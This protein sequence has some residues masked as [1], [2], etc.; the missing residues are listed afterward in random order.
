MAANRT[1]EIVELLRTKITSR[2]LLAGDVLAREELL[3]QDFGVSRACVRESLGILKAQG[4]LV[5]RRGKYGGT[6]ISTLIDSD[7]VD[8]LYRDLVLMD[9]MKIREILEARLLIE[10]EAARR[11]ASGPLKRP[12]SPHNEKSWLESY[13]TFHNELGTHANNPFYQISIR[14]FMKFITTF[15]NTL[16]QGESEPSCTLYDHDIQQ[17]VINAINEQE[18]S[19]AFEKMYLYT[20][21]S[22]EK[23]LKLE[24]QFISAREALF[25]DSPRS[26][27]LK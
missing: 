12:F 9:Q 2:Q 16:C 10:P 8:T 27:D 20:A 4:Y 6:F 24:P 21:L 26:Q 23:I 15:I 25:S 14:S 17:G 19:L 22:K 7:E 5:S 11:A 18:S 13:I 1:D 3:A